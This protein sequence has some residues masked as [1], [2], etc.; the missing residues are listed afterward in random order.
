[1]AVN[2]SSPGVNGTQ[3]NVIPLWIGGKATTSSPAQ[4]FP[5]YS[6][7][8]GKIVHDAQSADGQAATRAVDAASA[9]FLSWRKT[10]PQSRRDLLLRVADKYVAKTP[11]LVESQVLET[12][13]TESWARGNIAYA[14]EV[15]RESASRVTSISGDIP[16]TMS[17]D[18]LA[19]VFKEPIGTI[20]T[21]AP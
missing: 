13:C 18:R 3:G 15:I 16:Q 8:D 1:M 2:G 5:V 19:L 7:S 20:L 17:S 11:A 6:S 10:S 21:I 14:V 9:A 4:T 12:N